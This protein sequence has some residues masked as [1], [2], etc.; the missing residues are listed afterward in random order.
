METLS[1]HREGADA[2]EPTDLPERLRSYPNAVLD[3]Q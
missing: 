2:R 3:L 1:V